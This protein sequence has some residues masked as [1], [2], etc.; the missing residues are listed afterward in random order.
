MVRRLVGGG[1]CSPDGYGTPP[2][3]ARILRDRGDVGAEELSVSFGRGWS[4]D[5]AWEPVVGFSGCP[6]SMAT[7]GELIC[8]LAVGTLGKATGR[9]GSR[10]APGGRIR[11]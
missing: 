6:G 1:A 5:Q 4:A 8:R 7:A 3:G 11:R 2:G 9:P 10:R